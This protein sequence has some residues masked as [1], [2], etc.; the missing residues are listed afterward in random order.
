MAIR[1]ALGASRGRLLRQILLESALLAA[2]GASWA[3]PSHNHS[4]GL[5]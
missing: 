5:W 3:L 1:I 2:C 4:A